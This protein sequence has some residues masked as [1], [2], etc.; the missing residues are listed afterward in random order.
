MLPRA[1]ALYCPAT[2]PHWKT[3]CGA[4]WAAAPPPKQRARLE[5][6]LTV[7]EGSR[8]SGLERLRLSPISVSGPV[9]VRALE[10]LQDVRGLEIRLSATVHVA[11]TRHASL[12]SFASAVKV[13]SIIRLALARR[14]R[15]WSPSSFT[16]KPR[17]RAHDLFGHCLPEN[18]AIRES[19]RSWQMTV[20]GHVRG[21]HEL[22]NGH[23]PT[24]KR[25]QQPQSGERS[26]NEAKRRSAS[27]IC[28]SF[29]AVCMF[30]PHTLIY[31]NVGFI[32]SVFS[33]GY[34]PFT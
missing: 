29:K 9:L 11:P 7:P 27:W 16:W 15:R 32:E 26:E 31:L 5:G 3:G 21:F 25:L 19:F 33:W 20:P 28:P 34:F 17:P 12:A 18:A 13:T 23:T 24:H 8:A 6:L 10:R 22:S 4:R 30:N 2:W 14:W 1:R